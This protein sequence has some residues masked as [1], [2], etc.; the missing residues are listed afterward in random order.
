ME[1]RFGALR[2]VSVG[3]CLALAGC[4]H[5]AKDVDEPHA[6]ATAEL[7]GRVSATTEG[8]APIVVVTI[9]RDARKIMHRAF[10]ATDRIYAL[11]V[12]AGHYKVYAFMDRNR[13]GALGAQEPRSVVY[14]L[15]SGLRAGDRLELPTL[16]I[17]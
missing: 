6:T 10:L 2:A 1:K 5:L 14:A 13:D 15:A 17:R 7:R 12:P 11:P 16:T 8:T 3:F 4:Q 9:D